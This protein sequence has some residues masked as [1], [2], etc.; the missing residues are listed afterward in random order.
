MI[1]DAHAHLSPTEYGSL[2][3]LLDQ[4]AEAGVDGA[5]AVPGGM[6]DVRKMT[7]YITGRA[8]PENPEPNNEYVAECGAAEP[9]R[10]AGFY[11]AN[12]H[13][14]EAP[15]NLK[16]AFQ[17]GFRG[18]KLS[19]ISHQ[20]SFASQAVADLVSVCQSFGYPVYTHVLYNPGAS[21]AR[22]VSLARQFP[23]VNFVLGHTGFGPADQEGL[24]AAATLDNFYL[25]TS[26][27]NFLHLKE[28]LRRAGTGKL[29]FGSEFPLSHPK[30]ELE[31]IL[32]LKA[33]A[34]ALERILAGNILDLTGWK[35]ARG[36]ASG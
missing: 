28:C 11:C 24:E 1:I 36:V 33:P 17:S 3:L 10:V 34:S 29:I 14:P 2:R 35:P 13:D 19:P 25:E 8:Q 6:V 16:K 9:A 26:T 27:G 21:T 22:F 18:L 15:E 5:V 32:L 12:P 31:K 30:A 4:L 20:F 23:Q 7:D